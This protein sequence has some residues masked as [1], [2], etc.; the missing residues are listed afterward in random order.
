MESPNS[1][2][3]PAK[4]LRF[5]TRQQVAVAAA[6]VQDGRAARQGDVAERPADHAGP[7]GEDAQVVEVAAVR[8]EGA[9]C[10]AVLGLDLLE[11]SLVEDSLVGRCQQED[12]PLRDDEVGRG[13]LVASGP[14]HGDD[15]HVRR[16]PAHEL[17]DGPPDGIRMPHGDLAQ[18]EARARRCLDLRFEHHEGDVQEQDRPR[19]AERIGDRVA[20]RRVVVAEGG[21]RRLQ[22]R[23]AGARAGEQAQGVAE[24][25]THQL[26]EEEAHDAGRHHA[27]QRHQVRAT[28]GGAHEAYEELLAVLH[29]HG[30]EEQRQ[31]QGAHHRRRDCLGRE[32]AHRQRDEQHRPHAEREALDVDLAHEIADGDRQEQRHQRL[33]LEQ[34]PRDLQQS[35]R[36]LQPASRNWPSTRAMRSGGAGGV[37]AS[38]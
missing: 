21:D 9:R 2:R 38:R 14:A 5:R 27:R 6:H 19:H 37:S 15:L 22:G 33:L 23:G 7:R 31:A 30:I 32:P 1:L 13:H 18:L 10:L 29:A 26:H 11:D 20:Y 12:V 34:R 36:A 8:G 16:Q 24:V 25:E 3:R 4:S 35:H 17:A 28:P